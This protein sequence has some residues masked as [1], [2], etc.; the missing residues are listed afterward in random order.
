MGSDFEVWTFHW[1]SQWKVWTP[2][3]EV[4]RTHQSPK[5]PPGLC[6]QNPT[7]LKGSFKPIIEIQY[8]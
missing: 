1:D 8:K 3:S 5:M 4:L 2:E 6:L 7:K